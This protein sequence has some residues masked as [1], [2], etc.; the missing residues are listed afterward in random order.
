MGPCL[1]MAGPYLLTEDCLGWST[2]D[3]L[4]GRW[5]TGFAA[6]VLR[7]D[8]HAN[9]RKSDKR[10]GMAV[11]NRSSLVCTRVLPGHFPGVSWALAEGVTNTSLS[12]SRACAASRR[13]PLRS[14]L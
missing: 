12:E 3:C 4:K 10:R 13:M 14:W 8:K 1:P 2:G 5:T 6:L 11:A 9:G 7:G